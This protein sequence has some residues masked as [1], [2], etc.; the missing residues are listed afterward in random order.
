MIQPC[1]DQFGIGTTRGSV[2]A[3]LR[4]R[5]TLRA[6]GIAFRRAVLCASCPHKE[7]RIT[8]PLDP[9]RIVTDV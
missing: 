9:V 6:I 4:E 8:V 1:S 7:S 3:A 5:R 2:A